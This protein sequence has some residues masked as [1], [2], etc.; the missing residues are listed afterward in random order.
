M[1]AAISEL[2]QTLFIIIVGTSMMISFGLTL[3][4]CSRG[5]GD[6]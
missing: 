1:I 5:P 2:G 3:L 4:G 6:E